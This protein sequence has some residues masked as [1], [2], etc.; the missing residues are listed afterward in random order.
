MAL[1]GWA[2]GWAGFF[3]QPEVA[4]SAVL[5]QA[6]GLTYFSRPSVPVPNVVIFTPKV[7]RF[8]VAALAGMRLGK[9]GYLLAGP[10]LAYHL[11]QTYDDASAAYAPLV[12]HLYDS[13]VPVQLLAQGGVGT[14]LWRFDVS[15]RYEHSLTPYTRKFEY[16]GQEYAYYQ[17][18]SQ[19]I[20]NLG[21]L[22]HDSRRPSR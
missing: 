10:V 18:T 13:V 21:F 16:A 9:R 14:T 1:R 4:Y 8:E 15:A 22:L 6:Y 2:W 7:R 5:G 3:A 20:L 17:S 12:Q 11:R 19:V